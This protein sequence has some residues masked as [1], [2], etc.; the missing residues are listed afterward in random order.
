MLT[1][2]QKIL[3]RAAQKRYA[4]KHKE[5]VSFAIK[6]WN[7]ENKEKML[8]AAKKH[9]EKIKDNNEFKLLNSSKVKEWAKKNPHKV[10]EQSA[11]KRATKLKRVPCWLTKQDFENIKQIYL[12]AKQLSD[13]EGKKYHVDHIIP[14]RGKYVSGLHVPENLRILLA[15]ENMA[16]SNKFYIGQHHG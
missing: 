4:E 5:K 1:E 16:K 15:E 7:N 2:E 9:Y 10:L 8:E 13:K 11:R 12:E 6:K 3:R 14:L